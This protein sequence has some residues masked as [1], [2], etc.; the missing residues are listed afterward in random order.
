MNTR[1]GDEIE[2]GG[3]Q[4][5]LINDTALVNDYK[6]DIDK[7]RPNKDGSGISEQ[8]VEVQFRF[9]KE[10]IIDHRGM[11]LGSV[12]TEIMETYDPQALRADG[13]WVLGNRAAVKVDLDADGN[14]HLVL[15]EHEGMVTRA[16]K[17][18][19]FLDNEATIREAAAVKHAQNEAKLFPHIARQLEKENFTISKLEEGGYRIESK[20]KDLGSITISNC[21]RTTVA[22]AVNGIVQRFAKGFQSHYEKADYAVLDAAAFKRVTSELAPGGLLNLNSTKSVEVK[23]M[24]CHDVTISINKQMARLTASIGEKPVDIVLKDSDEHLRALKSDITEKG[25][26]LRKTG[27]THSLLRISDEKPV[28][29]GLRTPTDITKCIVSYERQG[30]EAARVQKHE[31]TQRSASVY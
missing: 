5:D 6:N 10:G 24:A 16:F 28:A 9:M 3:V 30:L 14:P 21:S 15:D 26:M 8:N 4:L 2:L 11:F 1:S 7:E 12:S 23:S 22:N 27:D 19:F 17:E 25:L 18:D 29:V 20:D 31:T 13:V